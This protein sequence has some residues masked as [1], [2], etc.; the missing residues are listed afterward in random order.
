[1]RKVKKI[2]K[3]FLSKEYMYYIMVI[4][5][6]GLSVTA[7]YFSIFGISHLFSQARLSVI[8]MA[9]TLECA[10]LISVSIRYRFKEYLSGKI[11]NYLTISVIILMMITSLGIYSY[12]VNAYQK[13][14]DSIESTSKEEEIIIQKMKNID[15]SLK[16]E[17]EKLSVITERFKFLN[18]INGEQEKRLNNALIEKNYLTISK[19]RNEIAQ[20]L[21]EINKINFSI[22]ES[23]KKIEEYNKQK[24]DL[25]GLLERI[26]KNNSKIVDIGP[27]KFLSRLFNVKIDKIV[28]I[29]IIVIIITFDPLAILLIYIA[30]VVHVNNGNGNGKKRKYTKRKKKRKKRNKNDIIKNEEEVL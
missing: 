10:K 28:N 11:K 2:Q 9:S 19:T 18:G 6:I 7:A 21:N 20:T 29:L 24:N 23:Q 13:V 3:K 1:M 22:D 25:N 8:I 17:N 16:T 27:L 14:S 12:L 26:N 4:V 5:A 30:N 15:S